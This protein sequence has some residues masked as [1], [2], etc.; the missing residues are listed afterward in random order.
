MPIKDLWYDGNTKR[1]SEQGWMLIKISALKELIE[2]DDVMRSALG[3]IYA[4]DGNLIAERAIVTIGRIEDRG[5][6]KKLA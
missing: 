6:P 2:I 5:F 3:R 1:S 4:E